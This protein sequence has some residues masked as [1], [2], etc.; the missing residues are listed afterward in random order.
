M[1]EGSE[2][3]SKDKQKALKQI[4]CEEKPSVLDEGKIN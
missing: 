1:E 4:L 3:H 2:K